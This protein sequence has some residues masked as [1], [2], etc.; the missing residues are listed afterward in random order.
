MTDWL[1]MI[2]KQCFTVLKEVYK[3]VVAELS[4]TV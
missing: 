3:N 4:Y 1:T 2:I